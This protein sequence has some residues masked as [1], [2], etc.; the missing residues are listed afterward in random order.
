MSLSFRTAAL[1][2]LGAAIFGVSP[3]PAAP[4]DA[5][6]RISGISTGPAFSPE[7]I[8]VVRGW[9]RE[10]APGVP[11]DAV[12]AAATEFLA[13]LQKSAP[14]KFAA[15]TLSGA[16]RTPYESELLRDLAQQ[17]S[18]PAQAGLRDELARR[19][20]E[21]L[22][23]H[24]QS[25]LRLLPAT[26]LTRIK[27]MASIY[28]RRLAEGRMDDDELAVLFKKA[29]QQPSTPGSAATSGPARPKELT[30]A[31]IVS[32]FARR[33]QTGSAWLRL[34]AYTTAGTLKTA[35]GA[36]QQLILAKLRPD[37][38]RLTV[39][40]GG[41]TR[42]ILGYNGA[43]YW[44][45]SP[46]E[47]AQE[48]RTDSIAQRKYLGEFQDPLYSEEANGFQ[49]L[50]DASVNGRKVYRLQVRRADKS[51]YIAQID[52]ETFRQV[53]REN[54]DKTSAHYEDFRAVAG[55]TFAFREGAV[56]AAG[57]SGTFQIDRVTANPGLTEDY[58]NPGQVGQPSYFD[59][60]KLLG[61]PVATAP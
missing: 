20:V 5:A 23:A 39:S 42:Y 36:E 11:A 37:R 12:A 53:G 38:F 44:Q 15:L 60:E 3:A 45:Q 33:N 13:D 31:E 51:E 30:T 50:P 32:E 22:L 25:S 7:H 35:S 43:H 34:R 55:V 14:E 54:P 19:R 49:R 40:E 4:G 27:E 21:S 18:A 9:M 47:P 17:L 46:G 28:Y 48:L 6:A 52:A 10:L 16:D 59:L 29:Q 1:C 24:G 41:V 8:E 58:F 56:D 26:A 2:L 57:R 61:A